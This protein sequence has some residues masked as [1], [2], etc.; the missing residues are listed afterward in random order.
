MYR[1]PTRPDEFARPSGCAA[2]AERSSSAAEFTAPQDT[3]NSGASTR[4]VSPSR[5]TSTARH[6]FPARIGEQPSRIGVGPERDVRPRDRRPHAA[7]VGLA[8]GVELTRERVAGI[9][10]DASR[11]EGRAAAGR[12]AGPGRE[13]LD[14]VRHAGRCGTAARGNAPRGAS[15]GSTPCAPRTWYSRSARS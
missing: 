3:M 2:V 10:Q 8:L 15:V 5:S 13:L 11:H 9:A 14:D 7:D 12:D 1:V 6:A 4:T